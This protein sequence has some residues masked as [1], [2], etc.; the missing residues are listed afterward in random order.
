MLNGWDP[1]VRSIAWTHC[2]H[3]GS[4]LKDSL[5]NMS[6]KQRYGSGMI[7]LSLAGGHLLWLL[8]QVDC[9]IETVDITCILLQVAPVLPTRCFNNLEGLEGLETKGFWT[10]ASAHALHL[11]SIIDLVQVFTV[12]KSSGKYI[13]IPEN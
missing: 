13:K 7:S 9:C 8:P 6:Q 12:L 1:G 3:S 2:S 5:E 4:L 10:A 11:P